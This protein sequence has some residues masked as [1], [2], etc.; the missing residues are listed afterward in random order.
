M[1][2]GLSKSSSN[3][4]IGSLGNDDGDGNE[5]GKKEVGLI[6]KTTTFHAHHAFWYISLPS[7]HDYDL[8]APKFTFCRGR[9]HKATTFFSFPEL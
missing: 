1:G 4:I 8:K 3:K 7:S 2:K 5:D 9:E 6:S